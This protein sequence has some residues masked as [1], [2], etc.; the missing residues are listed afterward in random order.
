MRY[1]LEPTACCIAPQESITKLHLLQAQH[2]LDESRIQAQAEKLDKILRLH[3]EYKA[4]HGALKKELRSYHDENEALE[5]RIAQLE[6]CEEQVKDLTEQNQFLEDKVRRL[7]EV[8]LP[9]EEGYER[10]RKMLAREMEEKQNAHELLAEENKELREDNKRLNAQLTSAEQYFSGNRQCATPP[11]TVPSRLG[12]VWSQLDHT[13]QQCVQKEHELNHVKQMLQAQIAIN[14]A[15]HKLKRE[16][17][18]KIES[19]TFKAAQRLQKIRS[20]ESRMRPDGDLSQPTGRTAPPSLSAGQNILEV[21]VH[22]AALKSL[23]E[24]TKSFV[25]VDFHAYDSALGADCCP[26]S[27][28]R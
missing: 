11:N 5:F 1:R 28:R 20:L 3:K 22:S 17:G 24:D 13:Q 19:L 25:L 10:E 27:R 15:K 16:M 14:G 4:R 2:K 21:N 26:C 23:P 12:D 18:K 9:K 7:C 6:D 8:N